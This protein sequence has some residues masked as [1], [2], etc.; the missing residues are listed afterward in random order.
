M[1][2]EIL[3]LNAFYTGAQYNW[4]T[5]SAD[6]QLQVTNAGTYAV[7]VSNHCGTANDAITV[8]YENCACTFSTPNAFSPNNDIKNEIFRLRN[9]CTVSDYEL[10][11]FN[12]WG[13]LLFRSTN[14]Q[15]GWNGSAGGRAQPMGSYVWLLQYKDPVSGKLKREK[16]V[17][18]LFR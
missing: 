18:T 14:Q 9:K 17:L 6:A 15:A 1:N 13:Q 11:I 7:V 10:K 3:L 16:G 8:K 2:N 5:G 12:R 4:N